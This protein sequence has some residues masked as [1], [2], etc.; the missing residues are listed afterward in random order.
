M[1]K[2]KLYIPHWNFLF[3]VFFLFVRL[4]SLFLQSYNSSFLFEKF[5]VHKFTATKSQLTP[6]VSLHSKDLVTALHFRFGFTVTKLGALLFPRS[7]NIC[8]NLGCGEK[9]WCFFICFPL[10]SIQLFFF[11]PWDVVK[12]LNCHAHFTGLHSM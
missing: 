8:Y 1:K 4:C 11:V 12:C 9:I 10:G 5:Q 6:S 3:S 7:W 2:I